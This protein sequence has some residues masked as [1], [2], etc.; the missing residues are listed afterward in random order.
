MDVARQIWHSRSP[1]LFIDQKWQSSL[2]W[3]VF[4]CGLCRYLHMPCRQLALWPGS[5]CARGGTGQRPI[6]Q[7]WRRQARACRRLCVL[8]AW[9]LRASEE[10][11][12]GSVEYMCCEAFLGIA[13]PPGSWRLRGLP[14]M[15]RSA[16]H[17]VIV[18]PSQMTL[19]RGLENDPPVV[20]AMSSLVGQR[21][22]M[23]ASLA[24][25]AASGAAS[26]C[27][28]LDS[29]ADNSHRVRRRTSSATGKSDATMDCQ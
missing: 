18:L 6:D 24:A 29:H 5:L 4:E 7:C 20:L 27:T 1:G 10:R 16:S 23:L 19:A 21:R 9:C 14:E 12:T 25:Q 8:S 13:S 17:C 15:R 22:C 28:R 2:R 26:T 11:G 3:G